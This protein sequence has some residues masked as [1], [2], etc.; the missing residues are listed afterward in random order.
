M[1]SD[2][3]YDLEIPLKID[4]VCPQEVGNWMGKEDW[5]TVSWNPEAR[6]RTKG[7]KGIT[8]P[9]KCLVI[10]FESEY[11]SLCNLFRSLDHLTSSQQ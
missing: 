2:F 1:E 4:A 3:G 11:S 5:P 6:K 8:A 9:L 7:S 10:I